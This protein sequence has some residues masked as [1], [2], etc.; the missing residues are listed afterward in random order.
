M[1]FFLQHKSLI[2]KLFFAYTIFIQKEAF[3]SFQIQ[4]SLSFYLSHFWGHES[5]DSIQ[6]GFYLRHGLIQSKYDRIMS[7]RSLSQKFSLVLKIPAF[8]LRCFHF[9]L[10]KGPFFPHFQLWTPV[11]SKVVKIL[12]PNFS[13][14]NTLYI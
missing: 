3:L 4:I 1:C 7:P 2:L 8:K 12:H 9:Y 5:M 10:I 14:T 6:R 11:I 13:G